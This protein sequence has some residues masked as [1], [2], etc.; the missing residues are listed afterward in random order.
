MHKEPRA[1][2]FPPRARHESEVHEDTYTVETGRQSSRYRALSPGDCAEAAVATTTVRLA[3]VDVVGGFFRRRRVVGHGGRQ[4][5]AHRLDAVHQAA[6]EIALAEALG[7]RR[8]HVVPE[9]LAHLGMNVLVA[10]HH[11]AAP[12]RH[13]EEQDTVAAEPGEGPLGGAPHVTPEPGRHRD[14]NASR[15][16]MLGVGDR[17]AHPRRVDL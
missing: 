3:D 13:Y 4:L 17:L 9:L 16:V 10:Q 5:A 1:K 15:G 11:E 12:P 6:G 14:V 7:D 2:I 8:R